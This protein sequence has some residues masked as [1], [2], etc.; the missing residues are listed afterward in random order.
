MRLLFIII[1]FC[2]FTVTHGQTTLEKIIKTRNSKCLAVAQNFFPIDSLTISWDGACKQKMANG[3]G[4]LTYYLSNVEVAKY[5][6]SVSNG[7]PNGSGRFSSPNGFVWEGNFLNGVLNGNGRVV[8]PDTTKKLE[9]NFSDGE[10]LNLDTK[11][12]S[13]LNKNIISKNDSTDLYLNDR[14]QKDLFYYSLVPPGKIKGVIVLL[15]GTWDRVEYTLS[16]TKGICQKAFDN[17]VAIISL[18]I[19]Q[20]LTLNDEVLLFINSAFKD[21]I[22][23]YSLP[24]DKFIIG[25]FSMGG[26]FSLRY[27]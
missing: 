26:L 14:N 17:N 22:Q 13:Q 4:T 12:L 23:K 8:F 20:R 27:V 9:G 5:K 15:P 16:S 2:L 10:I 11:Y 7:S 6:G 3:Q 24:Q 1:F 18:S 19:N 25:G 21:A